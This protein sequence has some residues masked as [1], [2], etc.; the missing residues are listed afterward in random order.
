MI[1][2]LRRVKVETE[3]G[4]RYL[5]FRPVVKMPEGRKMACD[6]VCPYGGK[7]CS[8]LRDPSCSDDEESSFMD[9]CANLGDDDDAK[10][11][12]LQTYIPEAGTIEENLYDFQN[13][14][15]VLIK[16]NGYVRVTDV[17]DSVCSDTCP[18]YNK[19]HSKCSPKNNTCLLQ[20]LLANANYNPNAE[21]EIKA[22]MEA[23]EK[24][25][26][27]DQK[28]Q[29][30]ANSSAWGNILSSFSVGNP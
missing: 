21:D 13:V 10:N 4:T 15:E 11:K 2:K 23:K 12:D 19:E 5:Q 7:L 16:N 3:N 9:F 25:D 27:E 14:Y 22:E 30:S 6:T 18:L 26:N 8:K 17:I 24:A 20:D 1:E 28:A 29:A